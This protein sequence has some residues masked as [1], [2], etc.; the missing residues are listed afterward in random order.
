MEHA[1]QML[2]KVVERSV[3]DGE[4]YRGTIDAIPQRTFRS[5]V[6]AALP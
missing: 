5:T 1:R 3:K 6:A 2:N 4:G